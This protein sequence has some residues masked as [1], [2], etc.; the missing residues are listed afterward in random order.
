MATNQLGANKQAKHVG[1]SD[2]S[3]YHIIALSTVKDSR[4]KSLPSLPDEPHHPPN[5]FVF[6]KQEDVPLAFATY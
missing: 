3:L 4:K 6:L 2:N 5:K 1:T